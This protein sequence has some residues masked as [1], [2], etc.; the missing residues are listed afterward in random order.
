M[1]INLEKLKAIENIPLSY[2]Q[3]C[4]E[5]RIDKKTG[6]SRK[7][8]FKKLR[9]WC[10]VKTFGKKYVI[11]NVYDKSLFSNING[12]NKFQIYIDQ[13][14]LEAFR[15]NNYSP[16]YWTKGE[17]LEALGLVNENFKLARNEEAV[18][19]LGPEYYYLLEATPEVGNI[20]ST[21]I[22][23][24]ITSMYKRKM[25][26]YSTGI[27]LIKTVVNN[28]K[29][30]F[31]KYD[32]PVESEIERKALKAMKNAREA[33][34][35]AE[36]QES[37]W[38]SPA[39]HK[40]YQE[41]LEQEL[42]QAFGPEYVNAVP[43]IVLRTEEYIVNTS[44]E[45]CQEIL[46]EESERKIRTTKRL[47]FLTGYQR[48]KLAKEVIDLKTDVKYSKIIHDKIEKEKSKDNDKKRD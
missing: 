5:L 18:R 34:L 27:R 10:E 32:L 28:N 35:P 40:L 47:N 42:K 9:D 14:I 2:P 1:D 37:S 7:A 48:E 16:L 46:N 3:L 44:I 26:L 19:I 39:Y 13:L 22:K 30:Y 25:L 41:A 21:W 45:R 8:F 24:R 4:E 29:Q 23:R 33:V 11:T 17:A 6:N 15:K 38:L 12:N 36:Y 31:I 20:L 43:V